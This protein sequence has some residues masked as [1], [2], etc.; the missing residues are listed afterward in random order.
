MPR[1]APPPGHD[2]PSPAPAD[3][4]WHGRP[5]ED[6]ARDL[7]CPVANGLDDG[8]VA[9]R[10]AR[11]GPNALPEA[12]RRPLWHVVVHQ[13]ES[14]LVWLLGIAAVLAFVLG[15]RGDAAV[16]LVVVLLN[17]IIGT[18]Q[19]GRAER[20]MEELRRLAGL[21]AR[22]RRGGAE[23]T[24]EAR[25]L[26][27]GDVLILAAGDAVAAD[28]R[29]VEAARLSVTEAA[30][31]GE[32]TPSNK[33]I[34]PVDPGAP[35]PERTS[36]VFAG[37]QVAGGRGVAV[38]VATGRAS[39][40]GRIAELTAGAGEPRTPLEQRIARFGRRLAVAALVTFA[41]VLTIGF[42]RGLP[43]LE[44]LMVATS[45]MVS[46]VP[47][48]LPV[49]VTIAL[50]VG[51]R[52]MARRG[53][54]VRRLGAVETLG[55]TTIICTDKTGTLTKNEM[56]VTD[57]HLADGRTLK[58]EG[59]GYAPD[60]AITAG[61]AGISG[62]SDPVLG[63][64]L[65]AAVLCNDAFVEPAD[66][67]VDGGP[68]DTEGT[69]SA[70]SPGGAVA[71]PDPGQE[72]P[73]EIERWVA[74][75]DPTE[76]ALV[77][78]AAKGG[79]PARATRDAWP[80]I[81]EI[82]F[83]PEVRMMA[84]RHR[85]VDGQDRIVIKGAP[86]AIATLCRAHRTAA[87]GDAPF[88]E[89][90]REALAAE[91]AGMA[92]RALRLLAL[93]E[94]RGVAVEPAWAS[95]LES[96]RGSGVFLGLVG[97]IDPPRPE[98]AKAVA[99]CRQA[100]IRPVM[101]T[102]DHKATGL[103]I[104]RAIGIADAHAKGVD[105]RELAAMGD[106]ELRERLGMI[107]V[108]ARVQ[109]DQKLRIVEACKAEGHVVAM[110]GDGV[111]DAPALARAGVGVAM[112]I[113]G[114]EVAKGASDIVVT[115][116][117]FATIV[118]AVCEG[119]LVYSNVRK[120]LVFLFATSLDEVVILLGALVA[121]LPLPLAAVQILWINLVTEGAVTVN[122][123][124]EPPEGDEMR[125][126]PIPVDEPLVPREMLRRI[127]VLV[128]SAV[129]VTFGFFVWKLQSGAPF[130]L[131]QTE[132]FTLLAVCQWFNVLN[133]R[134]ATRSTLSLDVLRNRWLLGGLVLANLLQMAVV[135]APAMNRIFH[136]VPIPAFDAVLI[137][138]MASTVLWVEEI[139]KLIARRRRRVEREAE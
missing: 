114:T 35:L 104:A 92:G 93:A 46:M 113:T 135:Y 27:P 15:E 72:M 83:D 30:L 59:T 64:L 1:P 75:G 26:V 118:E 20:S 43:W 82:P 138:L 33:S 84:T 106:A 23:R 48:G 101:V 52:R 80:R 36:M 111:N 123:I 121:G 62:E 45:Q 95:G 109:P 127:A 60:G 47:E 58:V 49:A 67:G 55:S 17:A 89:A 66:E 10:A 6:A 91:A 88:G 78:L 128:P 50:A 126:P 57:L 107:A 81:D 24:I 132:T 25:D 134:S 73:A 7:G 79:V 100:G 117:N 76:A 31:T 41:L 34:E 124:M 116:D 53:A 108:F 29:L 112:G 40:V 63:A 51:M 96:L 77:A 97:Q 19:E 44:V 16:V 28:A 119:R 42:L 69:S 94:V 120:V 110:T 133:C 131:V 137:G 65:E 38:V 54:I 5:A 129:A 98:A 56:T 125:R 122:L 8:E 85:S 21:R 3:G 99:R 87:G 2:A 68:G 9:A 14:P 70:P 102:G 13:F 86:E 74:V 39:E 105:G 61:G 103:A 139:R 11:F 130:A 18:V 32:S 37:T 115:D 90:E 71:A 22:V 12:E 136:T 4:A